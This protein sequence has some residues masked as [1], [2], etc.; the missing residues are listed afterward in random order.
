MTP[1]IGW[2]HELNTS[3]R[4]RCHRW[5]YTALAFAIFGVFATIVNLW[6]AYQLHVHNCTLGPG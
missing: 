4:A 2:L 3:W 5:A 6:L 1:K